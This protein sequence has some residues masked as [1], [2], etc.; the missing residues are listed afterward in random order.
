[1]ALFSDVIA[2]QTAHIT[3]KKSL[4]D[5]GNPITHAVTGHNQ[6]LYT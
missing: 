1:V 5:K 4:K 6:T 3:S 2:R